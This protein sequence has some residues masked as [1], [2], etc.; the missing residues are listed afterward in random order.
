MTV[1]GDEEEEYEPYDL[2]G[3]DDEHD[4]SFGDE[5]NEEEDDDEA[6]DDDVDD[7]EYGLFSNVIVGVE[8]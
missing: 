1:A 7:D 6:D 3:V 4:D 2:Y 8:S 5:E